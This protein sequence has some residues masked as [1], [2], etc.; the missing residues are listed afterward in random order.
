[1]ARLG[2]WTATYL[3]AVLLA[4]AVAIVAFGFFAPKVQTVL[5]GVGV[6]PHASF[7]H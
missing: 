6:L 7:S 3:R 1:M 2:T 5:A 4:W